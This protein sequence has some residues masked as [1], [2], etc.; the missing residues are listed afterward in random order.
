MSS[1]SPFRNAFDDIAGGTVGGVALC[2]VG[3]PLVRP[4]RES[5]LHVC[6]DFLL[7]RELTAATAVHTSQDTLKVRLQTQPTD[8]PLY[9]GLVDC[10]RKTVQ[11]EGFSGMLT[12]TAVLMQLVHAR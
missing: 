9:N 1:K 7:D 6:Y 2:L 11:K 3:H 10:F 8:K 4:S 12:L 5:I